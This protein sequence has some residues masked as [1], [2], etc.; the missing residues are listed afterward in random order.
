[1]TAF[2][3]AAAGTP[4]PAP[5]TY[6]V[7]EHLL[8]GC[9][10]GEF[11]GHLLDA[12]I[13]QFVNLQP[14]DERG[15]GGR[16][17]PAY[18]DHMTRGLATMTR[19]PIPDM[20][21]PSDGRMRAILDDI[22]ASLAVGQPTY[23][24]CWGGRGRTGTVVGCWLVRHG[25]AAPHDALGRLQQLRAGC[26]NAHAPSPETDEQRSMVLSWKAGA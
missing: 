11:V 20:G 13:R 22:D 7:S 2:S 17:F 12:G 3:L 1:M 23:V 18:L 4:A 24:H 26:A 9:Y 14:E 25:L 5:R 6:W 21:V 16:P 8:A 19:L 15:L 10:P